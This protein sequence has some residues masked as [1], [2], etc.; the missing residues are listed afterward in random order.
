MKRM[1]E[2]HQMSPD[3]GSS[4]DCPIACE[5][6]PMWAQTHFATRTLAL[7]M[8]LRVIVNEAGLNFPVADLLTSLRPRRERSVKGLFNLLLQLDQKIIARIVVDVLP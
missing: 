2:R 6:Q 3:G 7:G 5:M 1:R 8:S 4:S